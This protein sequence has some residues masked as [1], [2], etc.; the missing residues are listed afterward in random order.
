MAWVTFIGMLV[1]RA[2][3]GGLGMEPFSV[4]AP[5]IYIRLS[6]PLRTVDRVTRCRDRYPNISGDRSRFLHMDWTITMLSVAYR[7]AHVSKLSRTFVV[8]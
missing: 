8:V 2:G 6:D 1:A 3:V 5:C 4:G 7:E